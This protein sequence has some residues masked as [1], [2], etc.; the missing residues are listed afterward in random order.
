MLRGIRPLRLLRPLSFSAIHVSPVYTAVVRVHVDDVVT[1][2]G[3][4][5]G[6]PPLPLPRPSHARSTLVSLLE[7]TAY[8]L[9]T[10]DH[11]RVVLFCLAAWAGAERTQGPSP[12]ADYSASFSPSLRLSLSLS[13]SRSRATRPRFARL[14][15]SLSRQWP[16]LCRRFDIA[17]PLPVRCR[18]VPCRN[19][20]TREIEGFVASESRIESLRLSEDWMGNTPLDFR[21]RKSFLLSRWM[22][23]SF[24]LKFIIIL[25]LYYCYIIIFWKGEFLRNF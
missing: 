7:S 18:E 5:H 15:L 3:Y 8:F 19:G 13:V 1:L 22:I 4:R 9:G 23:F 20:E 12:F 24:R 16:R 14:A 17:N 10:Y 21:V 11:P 25:L 2:Q 6:S